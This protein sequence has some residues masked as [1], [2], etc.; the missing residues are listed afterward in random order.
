M[1]DS[2]VIDPDAVAHG[3]SAIGSA[4]AADIERAARTD[5]HVFI[6]GEGD[7]GPNVV[8]RLIHQRSR[9]SAAP[10]LILGCA[11]LPDT[12]LESELFGHLRGSFPGAYR[13]KPGLLDMA[14]TGTLF[15]DDVGEMSARLQAALLRFMDTGD[16][17]R[18]GANRPHRHVDVRIIAADNGNLR[19]QI[20]SGGF[21]EDLYDDLNMVSL[22]LP[23]LR[24]RREDIPLFVDF[25]LR[26]NSAPTTDLRCVSAAAMQLLTA[27]DWPGN[28][29]ELKNVVDRCELLG[30]GEVVEPADLPTEIGRETATS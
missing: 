8:A 13:D 10:M 17:Q 27:Y 24:E 16:V 1:K 15:L 7:A 5:A 9:R 28:V 21:R 29:N 19:S 6:V 2:A 25:F 22:V 26:E 4:L 30:R 18:V 12:L 14:T 23:P 11:G 3:L 20:A